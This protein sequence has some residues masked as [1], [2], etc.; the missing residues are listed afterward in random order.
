MAAGNATDTPVLT[1]QIT[2]RHIRRTECPSAA[3]QSVTAGSGLTGHRSAVQ[4]NVTAGSGLTG[5]PSAVQQNVT[6][7]SGHLVQLLESVT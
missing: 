3:K 7:G 6:A 2:R 4:Q 5:H 1:Y